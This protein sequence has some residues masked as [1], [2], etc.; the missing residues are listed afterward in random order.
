MAR[1]TPAKEYPPLTDEQ[2]ALVES[3]LRFAQRVSI[4]TARWI[5][6]HVYQQPSPRVI[7]DIF[8]Q[9]IGA[10]YAGLCRGAQVFEK[11]RGNKFLTC[12]GWWVR[13]AIGH[14]IPHLNLYVGPR[15]L[16]SPAHH[17]V[18][19]QSCLA[20]EQ[21]RTDYEVGDVFDVLDPHVTMW[22]QQQ[23]KAEDAITFRRLMAELAQVL[24]P[25]Y[26]TV[27]YQRIVMEL[28]LR[29]IAKNI[30]VTKERVRQIE[31][32]AIAKI[33]AHPELMA[34]LERRLDSCRAEPSPSDFTSHVA[35][36]VA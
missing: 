1:R 13:Q 27:L 24:S 28:P 29:T 25:R 7:Q 35:F 11:E 3:G 5:A 6:R 26:L 12:A 34:S 36:H 19:M 8:D 16:K 20:S 14:E 17:M 10:A 15:G 4:D 2:Q 9:L 31:E 23:K 32:K 21:N 18:R 22:D 30:G 33:R